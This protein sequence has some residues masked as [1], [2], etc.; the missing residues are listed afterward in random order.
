[1][2]SILYRHPNHQL[3]EFQSCFK[4]TLEALNGHNT[5]YLTCGDINFD[6]LKKDNNPGILNYVD[7]LSSLGC[8]S[9]I[10]YPTRITNNN[11]TAI[12]HIYANNIPNNKI[13]KILAYDIT[14]HVPV[15]TLIEDIKLKNTQDYSTQ[16]KR[17]TTNFILENFPVDFR[18][19][20]RNLKRGWGGA[21]FDVQLK[22]KKRSSRLST[23]NLPLEIK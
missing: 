5:P 1:M 21:I 7:A 15:L 23:F 9:F 3:S 12:D 17:S 20:P 6:L 18:G 4:A 14:D 10:N 2:I 19:V 8:K 13:R 11:S 22:T 16:F